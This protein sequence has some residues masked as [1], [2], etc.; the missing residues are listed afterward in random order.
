MG[1][2]VGMEDNT[3]ARNTIWQSHVVGTERSLVLAMSTC[4]SS[5]P[6]SVLKSSSL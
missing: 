1:V 5:R 6:H 2:W 3:K 4:T